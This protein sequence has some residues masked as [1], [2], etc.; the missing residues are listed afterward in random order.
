MPKDDVRQSTEYSRNVVYE[1]M[2]MRTEAQGCQLQRIKQLID[3]RASWKALMMI[4]QFSG[5]VNATRFSQVKRKSIVCGR[6]ALTMMQQE[7]RLYP[8]HVKREVASMK[9]TGK[10]VFFCQCEKSKERLS[11]VMTFNMSEQICEIAKY[12]YKLRIR[13]A[14]VSDLIASE[15]K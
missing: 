1:T 7:H 11:S 5:I 12:H 4:F 9:P 14:G 13:L 3:W 8:A 10:C 15:T 6:S 2:K